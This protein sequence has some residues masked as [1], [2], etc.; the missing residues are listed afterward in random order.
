MNAL[1]R[2]QW[3]TERRGHVGTE[4]EG[5]ITATDLASLIGCGFSSPVGVYRNKVHGVETPANRIMRMGLLT[6]DANAELY[7]EAH[8]NFDLAKPDFLRGRLPWVGA[9]LDR[10]RDDE[11]V[12]EL[13]YL[14][15]K[16]GQDWGIE[17]T[18]QV[19]LR[20]LVQ[21][22]WQMIVVRDRLDSATDAA[23]VSA[24]CGSGEHRIYTIQFD[25]ELAGMLLT[26]AADF[27]SEFLIPQVE[28]PATWA[29]PLA[30]KATEK[31]ATIEIGAGET[32][33]PDA[34]PIVEEYERYHQIQKEAEARKEALG[35]QLETMLGSFKKA[36]IGTKYSMGR[37]ECP[38]RDVPARYQESYPVFRV[39]LP[40]AKKALE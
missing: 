5:T 37:Y 23:D 2:K 17:G 10:I 33:I 34:L 12:V 25:A 14:A 35:E 15:F 6:E 21:T 13:K 27:R 1:Q 22:H 4:T 9:T 40:R 24:L 18:D 20:H 3:L 26:V 28:P 30:I 8:P 31:A 36:R 32:M 16:F 11:R 29:H 7:R 38:G 19:P 39:Y